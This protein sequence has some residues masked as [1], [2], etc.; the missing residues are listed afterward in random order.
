MET[1]IIPQ[2]VVTD[3]D[4][5]LP[6]I[7][8]ASQRGALI[9]LHPHGDNREA[10]AR[11]APDLVNV[12]PVTQTEPTEI[13]RNFGGF[14]DGDK[15]L[16]LSSMLGASAVLLVG[17]DFGTNI[18]PRSNLRRNEEPRK[19]LKLSIGSRLCEELV[20]RTGIRVYS[21]RPS[22]FPGVLEVDVPL[23]LKFLGGTFP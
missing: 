13:V 18:G 2:V 11:Y 21:L 12:I 23:A 8:Q 9:I 20:S 6:D 22:P 5:Y 14:T 19:V 3:L 16:F 17:M 7:I 4:G 15:C 10:V 1:G